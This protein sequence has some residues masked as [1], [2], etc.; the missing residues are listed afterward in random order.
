[1]KNTVLILLLLITIVG[2]QKQSY[3]KPDLSLNESNASR[4][5]VY[6]PKSDWVGIAIDYRVY[7]DKVDLGSLSAGEYVEAF[8]PSET[9]TIMVQGHFLGFADGEAVEHQLVL[10]KGKT[11]Y[12]RFTQKFDGVIT[13]GNTAT[14]KGG[15]SLSVVEKQ[16]FETLK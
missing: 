12:L 4:L 5:I 8:I 2:C 7:A 10:Q 3:I 9:S 6:R 1:M 11:Y 16:Y 15:L 13:I 14:I